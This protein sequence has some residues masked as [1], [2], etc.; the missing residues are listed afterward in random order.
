METN[1]T[2]QQPTFEMTAV[3]QMLKQFEVTQRMGQMYAAA[4]IVP[5]TYKGN[6]ANC[7]IAI[8][9]AIRM[10]ADPM[11]VM[12]NLYMVN[13][14][15]S[16]SSK[17]LVSCIN[18]SGR[19]SP[20]Q[21][22]MEYDPKNPK[23]VVACRAY[24]FPADYKITGD[25]RTDNS[26]RLDGD[27]I[28]WDMVEKEGWSKKSGSKWMTMP[29]QMFRYRAAA[30]WQRA[31]CPEISMGFLTK[32]EADEVEWA[33]YEEVSERKPKRTRKQHE[34]SQMALEHLVD[35]ADVPYKGG[36]KAETEKPEADASG[37]VADNDEAEKVAVAAAPAPEEE[38]KG[39]EALFD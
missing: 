16:F 21:Y 33:E 30:F 26:H 12:Q 27:W 14:N 36:K 37:T 2:V 24:A 3:G 19:F 20:L 29:G 1:V 31:Y 18:A 9:M 32:E 35:D 5:S 22:E 4:T 10:Q 34:E 25:G 17:F 23:R 11:M 8:N 28:T 6:V 7:A 15:P 39:L 13:N 38:K